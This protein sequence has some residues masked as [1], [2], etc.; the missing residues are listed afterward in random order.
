MDVTENSLEDFITIPSEMDVNDYNL[1]AKEK[2]I[3]SVSM[4]YNVKTVEKRFWNLTLSYDTAFSNASSSE[5]KK[6][7]PWKVV[8]HVL[9]RISHPQL[10]K[11]A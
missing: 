9:A 8:T 2:V 1:T 7:G 11:R 6:H 5:F 4:D 3:G 10:R